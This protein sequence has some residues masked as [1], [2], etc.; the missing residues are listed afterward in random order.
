MLFNNSK[1]VLIIYLYTIVTF[2]QLK[3]LF[4]FSFLYLNEYVINQDDN[5]Q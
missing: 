1:L 3:V 4:F 5:V 2:N